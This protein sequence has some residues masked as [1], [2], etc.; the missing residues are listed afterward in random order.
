[1]PVSELAFSKAAEA[2]GNIREACK[3]HNVTEQTFYRWRRKFFG[4]GRHLAVRPADD[5]GFEADFF[6]PHPLYRM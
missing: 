2:M 1:M 3:E 6:R 5:S 4:L